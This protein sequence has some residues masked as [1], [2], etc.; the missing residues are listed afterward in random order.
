MSQFFNMDKIMQLFITKRQLLYKS[1]KQIINLTKKEF[2][3][4]RKLTDKNYFRQ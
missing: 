2:R 3:K 1:N 4:V